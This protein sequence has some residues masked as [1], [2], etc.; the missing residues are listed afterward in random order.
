METLIFIIGLIIA[1]VG[2]AGCILPAIPGPPLNFISIIILELTKPESFSS[3]FLWF[4]GIA[5]LLTVVLDYILPIMGAK[6]YKATKYG[7]WGSVIGMLIGV[8]FFPP[9]G[10]ILG[11]L[12]GAIA[13]ELY[14]GKANRDALK[15]GF[16]TF[17][18]SLF[19]ILLKLILSALMTYYFIERS[20]TYLL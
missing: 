16:V 11:L 10:M 2:L 18:A 13:G 15:I 4:W 17:A 6:I 5:T 9:F 3:E 8:I 12:I 20:F 19:M 7:I 1:L 14:A